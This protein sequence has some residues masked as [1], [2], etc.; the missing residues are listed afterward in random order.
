LVQIDG[1][2]FVPYD[3]LVLCTGTQYHVP[4]PTEADLESG[5]TN[6]DIPPNLPARR[7]VGPPPSNILTINSEL[8]AKNIL[9]YISVHP[10]ENDGELEVS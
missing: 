7:L 9:E 4:M 2:S 1:A 8:D 3:Y 10:S 5:A 6:E